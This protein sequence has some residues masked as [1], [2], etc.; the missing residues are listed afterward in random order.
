MISILTISYELKKMNF[1]LI[2]LIETTSKSC[3]CNFEIVVLSQMFTDWFLFIS[4]LSLFRSKNCWAYLANPLTCRWFAI[5]VLKKFRHENMEKQFSWEY[6][7][8]S[9]LFFKRVKRKNKCW[10]FCVCLRVHK[11]LY[12]HMF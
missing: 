1:V 10:L 8:G 11:K 6:G 4:F 7:A 2:L 9:K 5:S 3:K 12:F